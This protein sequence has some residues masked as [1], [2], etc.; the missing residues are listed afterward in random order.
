MSKQQLYLIESFEVRDIRHKE[1]I[2]VYLH[3]H[4]P[5]TT[6]T[7]FQ[8]QI[9]KNHILV[10]GKFADKAFKLKAG[11]RVEIFSPYKSKTGWQANK[12]I[13]PDIIYEDD[14]VIVVTKPSGLQV[15][16][17]TG[18]YNNTLVNGLVAYLSESGQKPLLVHRL[19]K[20]TEGLMVFA[21]NE[22]IRSNLNEQFLQK[23][24]S[25]KYKALVWG[26]LGDEGTIDRPIGRDKSEGNMFRVFTEGESGGKH[27]VTHYRM[28]K[29]FAFHSWVEC[30][31]E[32]GRTHQIRVHFQSIGNPLIGDFEY[33]GN[34]LLIG[35]R[36]GKYIQLMDKL[37]GLF[38]G[39]ALVAEKLAFTH[40]V[41][42]DKLQFE[43]DLPNRF[44]NAFEILGQCRVI[45]GSGKKQF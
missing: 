9:G 2:D 23:K 21:K 36:D 20:F 43:I 3:R 6:R 31:L 40:P 16:P 26:K 22:T 18:N 35:I 33:G 27:A 25:R 4:F 15:H 30:E 14:A 7:S 8:K 32:T 12:Q 39:Q 29:A 37:L 34:Q 44:K 28:V 38:K 5:E 24:A 41:K 11:D 45:F 13:I 19:D 1:R 42:G 17:A 10:N